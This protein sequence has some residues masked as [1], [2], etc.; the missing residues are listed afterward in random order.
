[1]VHSVAVD[2]Q[3]RPWW[4]VWGEHVAGVLFYGV[5]IAMAASCSVAMEAD[6]VAVTTSSPF[7]RFE[8]SHSWATLAGY[9]SMLTLFIPITAAVAAVMARGLTWLLRRVTRSQAANVTS[10]AIAVGLIVSAVAV[11]ALTP[12]LEE[13]PSRV[14]ITRT[15]VEVTTERLASRLALVDPI[16]HL[17]PL[18]DIGMVDLRLDYGDDPHDEAIIFLRNGKRITLKGGDASQMAG[19][20]ELAHAIAA[21]AAVDLRC[22][23]GS[24]RR[25]C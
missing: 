16:V 7:A 14:D 23:E 12:V 20:W 3:R 24:E 4:L 10:T 21:A 9:L 6:L 11:F 2:S 18:A 25:R 19:T 1:M 5:L 22:F 15:D 13:G 8:M 17:V